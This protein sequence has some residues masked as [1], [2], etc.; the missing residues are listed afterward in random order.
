MRGRE[1]CKNK[2]VHE[3]VIGSD[4]RSAAGAMGQQHTPNSVICTASLTEGTTASQYDSSSRGHKIR[5]DLYLCLI[6][7]L[8]DTGS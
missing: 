6:N 8:I 1:K 2:P 7:K 3:P 4:E 5:S